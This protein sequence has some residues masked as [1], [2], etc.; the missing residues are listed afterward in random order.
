MNEEED[1]SEMVKQSKD[2]EKLVHFNYSSTVQVKK[3]LENMRP[4]LL[5]MPLLQF[6]CDKVHPKWGAKLSYWLD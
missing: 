5:E 1:L 2:K 4:S 6:L 3:E